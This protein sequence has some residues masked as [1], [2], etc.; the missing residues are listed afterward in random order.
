[1]KRFASMLEEIETLAAQIR[2]GVVGAQVDTPLD[3]WHF[4]TLKAIRERATALEIMVG[5]FQAEVAG[6]EYTEPTFELTQD[7]AR[8]LGALN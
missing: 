7:H 6:C 4:K 5:R 8:P 1:M 2:A 3:S